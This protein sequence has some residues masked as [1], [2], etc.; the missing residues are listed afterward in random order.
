[1]EHNEFNRAN[2]TG[3]RASLDDHYPFSRPADNLA[4]STVRANIEATTVELSGKLNKPGLRLWK[5][6]EE[7]TKFRG[8]YLTTTA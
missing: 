8:H 2:R 3:S 1:M 5:V 6:F 4:L 7:V